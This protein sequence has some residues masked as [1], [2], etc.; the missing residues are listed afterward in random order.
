MVAIYEETDN[1]PPLA[2]AI[3]GYGAGGP[4]NPTYTIDGSHYQ[5]NFPTAR[6]ARRYRIEVYR[7]LS[8]SSAQVLGTKELNTK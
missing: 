7:P 8:L 3:Y 2:P 4:K 6:G 1:G 5:L